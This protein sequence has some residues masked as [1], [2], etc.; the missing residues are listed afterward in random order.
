M[1]FSLFIFNSTRGA[2]N[3][4]IKTSIYILLLGGPSWQIVVGKL[5]CS[6]NYRTFWGVVLLEF[7]AVLESMLLVGKP[8]NPLWAISIYVQL[9]QELLNDTHHDGNEDK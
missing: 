5:M 6:F 2:V 9:A 1:L 8:F 3:I 7:D 4:I